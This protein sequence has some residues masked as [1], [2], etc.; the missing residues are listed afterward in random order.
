M[1]LFSKAMKG[2]GQNTT[3]DMN[4]TIGPPGFLGM[5]GLLTAL[6]KC[7]GCTG[8]SLAMELCHVQLSLPGLVSG[9]YGWTTTSHV[10][11]AQMIIYRDDPTAK[12]PTV[13]ASGLKLGPPEG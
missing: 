8:S 7:G 2:D 9:P 5:Y 6:K 11:F 3:F 4:N 12:L 13:A 1:A 10:P